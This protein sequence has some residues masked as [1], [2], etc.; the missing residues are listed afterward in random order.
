MRV[1]ASKWIQKAIKRPGALR[2]KAQAAGATMRSGKIDPEWLTQAAKQKGQT[3]RQ[4]RLALTLDRLRRR[5]KR[6]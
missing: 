4:A 2:K 3:G 6:G 5:K 1:M